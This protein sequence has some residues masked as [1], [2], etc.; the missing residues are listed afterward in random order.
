MIYEKE[1]YKCELREWRI[2][3]FWNVQRIT[4]VIFILTTHPLSRPPLSPMLS[5]HFSE[6]W[7]EGQGEGSGEPS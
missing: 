7:G 4:S 6:H 3:F 5:G 2:E 1:M